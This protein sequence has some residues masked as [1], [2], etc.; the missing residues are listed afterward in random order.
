[1]T[2]TKLIP[3]STF[4]APA[5][6]R[7]YTFNEGSNRPALGIIDDFGIYD[8]NSKKYKASLKYLQSKQNAGRKPGQVFRSDK[9]LNRLIEK[10][11]LR[12]LLLGK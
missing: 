3:T 2:D 6:R 8:T 5:K 10:Q 1:M 12:E 4:E 11:K 9:V 7:S